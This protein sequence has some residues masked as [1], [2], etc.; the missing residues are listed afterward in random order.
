[1]NCNSM[2][3]GA[4]RFFCVLY[5]VENSHAM[6]DP[7]Q[8]VHPTSLGTHPIGFFPRK[9]KKNV[10]CDKVA[11]VVKG[12]V[13]RCNVGRYSPIHTHTYSEYEQYV[14]G[15]GFLSCIPRVKCF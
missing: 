4:T 5:E 12:F 3:K 11:I 8:M 15:V 9:Q 1:M 10:L 13:N 14:V 2:V 6:L 7:D